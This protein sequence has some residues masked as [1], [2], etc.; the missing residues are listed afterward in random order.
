MRHKYISSA[1]SYIFGRFAAKAHPKLAQKIIN[2][3]YVKTLR[4]DMSEFDPPSA[5]PT[6]SAL[7]TRELKITRTLTDD[8]TAVIAPCDSFITQ[9]GAIETN[10]LF[11]IKG[12]P[13][14]IF[15]LLPHIEKERLQSFDG[16]YYANFYL[17][18]RDYHRYHAPLLLTLNY[19]TH[20]PGALLPVNT[21]FLRRKSNLFCENE[22]AVLEGTD[23]NNKRWILVFVGALNVGKIR[24]ERMPAFQTNVG[25]RLIKSFKLDGE[26]KRGD[27]LGYFEMGSTIVLIAEKDA[28][29]FTIEANQKIRFGERIATV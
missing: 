12:M 17:S 8:Q 6:L 15:S 22:R 16:G 3:L 11:Q 28:A 20:I 26:V 13:Y 4:L 10:T 7:F 1:V 25:A 18:P 21:P 14:S 29:R 19:L 2:A 27:L 23:S 5:Y 24:F 9:S